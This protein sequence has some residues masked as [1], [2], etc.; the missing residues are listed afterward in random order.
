MSCGQF[1]AHD[2]LNGLL[3]AD[4]TQLHI[5]LDPDNEF[6][7]SSFLSKLEHCN[8]D[9]LKLNDNK[10]NIL[11]LASPHCVKFLKTLFKSILD[12]RSTSNCMS[13]ICCIS[14]RLL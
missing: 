6:N 9:I 11:Y 7:F 1:C 12:T 4:N 2:R 3:H 8:V 13:R 14:Y 10:T 5:S